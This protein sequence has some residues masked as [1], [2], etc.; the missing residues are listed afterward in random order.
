LSQK[1]P[2]VGLSKAKAVALSFT[3]RASRIYSI[4][5]LLCPEFTSTLELIFKN[6]LQFGVGW[7]QTYMAD[8]VSKVG[9]AMMAAVLYA[10]CIESPS[11]G[12]I[13]S[14]NKLGG[15]CRIT[16]SKSPVKSL[17]YEGH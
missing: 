7:E 13:G 5:H 8:R 11:K 12:V 16:E 4:L 10:T 3:S 2:D 1:N 6:V 17:Q 9:I 15:I 14:N